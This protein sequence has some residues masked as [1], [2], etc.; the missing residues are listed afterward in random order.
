MT[1]F[2]YYHILFII[3]YIMATDNAL[4]RN[5]DEYLRRH[6]IVELMEDLCSDLTYEQP[7][8]INEF[9]IYRLKIKQKQGT[10]PLIQASKQASSIN[11]KYSTSSPS[12]TSNAKAS[13]ISRGAK[14]HSKLWP[15]TSFNG[16]RCRAQESLR[17]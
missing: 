10:H 7:Q 11:S 13:S 6:R 5:A 15:T 16:S 8:N 1:A 14:R 2:H 12:S 3:T 4:K 17:K 9:L